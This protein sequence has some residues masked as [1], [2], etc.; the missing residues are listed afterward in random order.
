[1][2]F[3][4][5]FVHNNL[6]KKSQRNWNQAICTKHERGYCELCFNSETISDL[7]IEIISD[8]PISMIEIM[9]NI[10]TS[11]IDIMSDVLNDVIEIMSDVLNNVI[12]IMSDMIE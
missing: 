9:N 12:E 1:M 5:Q 11:M 10:L 4:K 6:N 2:I 7:L 8:I 3:P